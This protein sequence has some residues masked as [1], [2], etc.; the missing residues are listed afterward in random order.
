VDPVSAKGDVSEGMLLGEH[1]VRCGLPGAITPLI[2]PERV[3]VKHTGEKTHT[4]L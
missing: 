2:N 1:R 4:L 3:L